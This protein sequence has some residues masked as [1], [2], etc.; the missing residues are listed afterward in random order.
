MSRAP[1]RGRHEATRRALLAD[2]AGRPCVLCGQPMLPGQDLDLDHA[3]D[4]S[5]Y[6]GMAHATCNRAD[7]GRRGSRRQRQRRR[8]AMDLIGVG[9]LAVEVAADRGHTSIVSACRL[10]DDRVAG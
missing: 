2:A 9:V 8:L 1:Y 5:G 4:G 6:R 3:P 7:G 10:P